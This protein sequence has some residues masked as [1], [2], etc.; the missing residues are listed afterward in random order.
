[1]GRVRQMGDTLNIQVDLVDATTGAQL[2]G[3]EYER[4]VSDILSVKQAIAREVT[5]NLR[6]RLSGE[7]Q[8]RLVRRDTTNA[9][10]YQFYLRGRFFWNK[11]TADG[12]RKAMEQF[13]Q[14]IDRDPNYALGHVGLADCYLTLEEY[15]GVPASETLPK[16]RAAADRALQIDDSLA[17][18]HASSAV[19]YKKLWRWAEAEQEYKRAISL[20]PNYSTVHHWFA[21]YFYTRG[22]FD[23]AMREIKRAQ[24]LDPLSAVI[25]NNVSIVYLLK[26]DP[27]SAIEQ[28]NRIIELDPGYPGAREQLGWAYLKQ[29]RYEEATAEF[30]RAVELSGRGSTYLSSLGYCYAVTGR[31]AEALAI[32][33]E[34]EEGYA[35]RKA[36]AKDLAGVY[37]GLGE[38]DQAFAWLERGFEQRSGE[39]PYITTHFSFEDLRSDPRYSDLVRRMGL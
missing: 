19:T 26:N 13:Q 10:V 4:K 12:I 3:E 38:K 29:R 9:E 23:D 7:E 30:Q 39:L 21:I 1:M 11:R 5:E 17:E 34:L 28:C 25:S 2:W 27:S 6:L 37:A 35:R 15:A 36:I 14:A 16:A 31:R 22:Q 18:A 33:K 20:N 8:R 24:A 32:L